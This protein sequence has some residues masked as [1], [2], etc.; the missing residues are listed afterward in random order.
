MSGNPETSG[1]R[2]RVILNEESL[3]VLKSVSAER[4]E[5]CVRQDD[6]PRDSDVKILAIP[7][8]EPFLLIPTQR[9]IH[10]LAKRFQEFGDATDYHV[11][12]LACT[13]L[14]GMEDELMEKRREQ[15]V[16]ALRIADKTRAYA[17]LFES[18]DSWGQS[19]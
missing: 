9:D 16:A 6:M 11:D 10:E 8:S 3:E 1:E 2:Y 14:E 18:V 15:G 12:R 7:E 13:A 17:E 19:F 5:H 4:A